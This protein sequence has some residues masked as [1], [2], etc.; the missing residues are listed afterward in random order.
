[1][2]KENPRNGTTIEKFNQ[3]AQS[4]YFAK[5][6]QKLFRLPGDKSKP[7]IQLM[8]RWSWLNNTGK[9][10]Q[11]LP[12]ANCPVCK[13]PETVIHYLLECDAFVEQREILKHQ[14]RNLNSPLTINMLFGIRNLSSKQLYSIFLSLYDYVSSTKRKKIGYSQSLE[15][16]K[17][18]LK[19]S[20]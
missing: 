3:M 2:Q 5:A 14:L 15:H 12:N 6:T 18:I 19:S 13:K 4:P 17:Q 7:I 8:T 11:I 1:M 16:W 20:T 10:Y 9:R